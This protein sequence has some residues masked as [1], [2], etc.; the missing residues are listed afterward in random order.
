MKIIRYVTEDEH[1][2][3]RDIEKKLIDL[4]EGSGILFVGV[5]VTPGS[6]TLPSIFNIWIGCSRQMDEKMMTALVDV[7][8]R[9]EI[10]QGLCVKVQA[11]RGLSRFETPSKVLE[12][13]LQ[14]PPLTQD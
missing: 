5:S 14:K 8:L 11:H 7:V 13:F 9:E 3:A 12:G 4:P 6:L 1:Q 10:A 2:I